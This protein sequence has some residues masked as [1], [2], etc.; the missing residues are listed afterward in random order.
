V[1]E[2]ARADSVLSPAW[3]RGWA[4]VPDLRSLVSPGK[5]LFGVPPAWLEGVPH[6]SAAQETAPFLPGCERRRL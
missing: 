3:R 2:E 1:P 5:F 4:P 6:L